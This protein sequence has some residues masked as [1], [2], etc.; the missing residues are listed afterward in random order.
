M[1]SAFPPPSSQTLDAY[2]KTIKWLSPFTADAKEITIR[3][4]TDWMR[5]LN[6]K[7]CR[8]H[9]IWELMVV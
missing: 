9:R 5:V 7:K 8:F 4:G 3:N 6:R 1:G 2:N